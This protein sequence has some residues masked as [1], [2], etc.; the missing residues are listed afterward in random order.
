MDDHPKSSIAYYR[1]YWRYLEPETGKHNWEMIDRQSHEP[2][3]NLA[4]AGRD[5][6]GWYTLGEIKIK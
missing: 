6:E 5:S 1:V 4:I 2:K 3:V